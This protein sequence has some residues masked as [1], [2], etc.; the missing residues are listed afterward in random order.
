MFGYDHYWSRDW[1][2]AS[3]KKIRLLI[4]YQMILTNQRPVSWGHLMAEKIVRF[5]V[6]KARAPHAP[7]R[8]PL[9]LIDALGLKETSRKR[10]KTTRV[11]II[12]LGRPWLAVE[13]IH[14]EHDWC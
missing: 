8:W 11:R 14:E 12:T 1:A 10:N 2:Q 5:P 4:G 3:Q 6:T 7:P 9:A 13:S